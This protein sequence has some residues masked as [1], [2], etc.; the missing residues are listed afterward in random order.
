MIRNTT[1]LT[2]LYVGFK[3]AFQ[4]G[5][6]G[7][8]P[9]YKRV[10][11]TAPS[12]TKTEQYGW[13]GTMPNIREWVGDRVVN[14]LALHSYSI[15]NKKWEFTLGVPVDDIED[16]TYGVFSPLF[17]E[18]GRTTAIFP[19]QLV[20]PALRNGHRNLCYD[21]QNF[22]DTEHPGVELVTDE[23]TGEEVEK[24]VLVSNYGGGTGRFWCLL[25]TT[26]AIKPIIFQDRK[27]FDFVRLDAATDENVFNRDEYIYGT[28]GR[29]NV[30]Y[31]FW[32]LAYGS[33][34]PLTPEAYEAAR[35][36]LLSM[37][38][39]HGQPLGVQPDL[40]VVAPSDEGAA[41]KILINERDAN[42]AS[43]PW[44]GTAELMLSHWFG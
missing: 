35:A 31:G 20:W 33:R 6:D 26:R 34:Q 8:K 41:K 23:K 14:S 28:K 12:T 37:K 22:F 2:G 9:T 13:L 29:S 1:N 7:V 17:T 3:T 27:K 30:G 10:A 39:D 5:F 19:D 21:G 15:T 44:K 16:D 36:A 43:N 18:M 32:Q 42:G 4:G 11:M 25:D 24:P 40:L 38:G